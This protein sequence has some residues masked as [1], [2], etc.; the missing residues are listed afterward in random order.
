MDLVQNALVGHN[1]TTGP[2][3]YECME[4][5][6]KGDAK[7]KFTQQTNLLGSCTVGNF[8][9]VTATMT[10]HIFPVLTY[11]EQKRYMYRYLR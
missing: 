6:L 10:M 1:I 5:V 4:W 9:T 2:T 11:P 3:I 8:T 7:A